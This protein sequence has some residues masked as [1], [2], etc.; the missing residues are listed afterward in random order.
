MSNN[1]KYY[2]EFG[3][4]EPK[5]S[6]DINKY[7]NPYAYEPSKYNQET[8]AQKNYYVKSKYFYPSV[9]SYE[10][11]STPYDLNQKRVKEE[12]VKK[13]GYSPEKHISSSDYS[14]KEVKPYD[15]HY[16]KP[17]EEI[18]L[19][20]KVVYERVI[21]YQDHSSPLTENK[22]NERLKK[23]NHFHD[24]HVPEYEL[25]NQMIDKLD[26]MKGYITDLK[27]KVTYSPY[28]SPSN[29][30][31]K[32][33]IFEYEQPKYEYKVIEH[34]LGEKVKRSSPHQFERIDHIKR[35]GYKASPLKSP[36]KTIRTNYKNDSYFFDDHKSRSPQKNKI[37]S[38][39]IKKNPPE[40]PDLILDK[41][42]SPKYYQERS[43]RSS[44]TRTNYQTKKYFS[45]EIVVPSKN[46]IF[47]IPEQKIYMKKAKTTDINEIN[48]NF[49]CIDCEQYIKVGNANLHS[50]FCFKSIENKQEGSGNSK[51]RDRLRNIIFFLDDEMVR[52]RNKYGDKLEKL[53]IKNYEELK[54]CLNDILECKREIEVHSLINRLHYIN[55]DFD[56]VA[57]PYG[58][59]IKRLGL[60]A[61]DD[62][63]G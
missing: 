62:L 29:S 16:Y 2:S 45:Q 4:D 36:L 26:E 5:L 42:E 61:E 44:P 50:L 13:S 56:K 1:N 39:L 19:Q 21:S 53:F 22:N 60:K 10:D 23:S 59:E 57:A 28:S 51:I 15:Y 11:Y 9:Y 18:N 38:P 37:F 40:N 47:E 43:K 34:E 20:P 41:I 58:A 49:F 54:K 48:D 25:T 55:L 14:Y 31:P 52:I 30:K 46:P 3:Y 8:L 33:H 35:Y 7:D 12:T 63:N 6:N 32:P 17:L 24:Y 27:Q